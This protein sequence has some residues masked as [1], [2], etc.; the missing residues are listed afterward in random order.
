[1]VQVMDGLA[2][3]IV[4]PGVSDASGHRSDGGLEH[5]SQWDHAFVNSGDMEW[6]ERQFGELHLKAIAP[7]C[8]RG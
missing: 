1:M 3:R 8:S 7:C 2:W 6:L 4:R 5:V